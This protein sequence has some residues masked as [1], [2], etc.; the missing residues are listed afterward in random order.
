[1]MKM[2][3]QHQWWAGKLFV[4]SAFVS[5]LLVPAHLI[6]TARPSVVHRSVVFVVSNLNG[7]TALPTVSIYNVVFNYLC[8]KC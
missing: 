6:A 5:A 4:L 2:A 1:M 8:M 3:K 7:C